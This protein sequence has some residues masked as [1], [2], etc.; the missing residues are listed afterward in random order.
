MHIFKYSAQLIC[1]NLSNFTSCSAMGLK[2]TNFLLHH[3]K[4]HNHYFWCNFLHGD[5]RS[6]IFCMCYFCEIVFTCDHMFANLVLAESLK[7][8]QN[9]QYKYPKAHI[10]CLSSLKKSRGQY[11]WIVSL[12]NLI[13]RMADSI[14]LLD[15]Y[16]Y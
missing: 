4:N 7:V 11:F 9:I 12:P 16:R 2:L 14:L 15:L 10:A 1:P 3:P 5:A 8:L 13:V 6:L